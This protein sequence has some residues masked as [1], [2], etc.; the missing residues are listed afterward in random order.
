[1][2]ILKSLILL[3]V[4][5]S[6]IPQVWCAPYR[7]FLC[8]SRWETIMEFDLNTTTTL[9]VEIK[10]NTDTSPVRF[11]W[12]DGTYTELVGTTDQNHT[13]DY[14]APVNYTVKIKASA[15]NNLTKLQINAGTGTDVSFD[16]SDIPANVTFL[17]VPAAS[18]TISGDI[19]DAPAGITYFYLR[20]SNTISGDIADAPAGITYF[21]LQGSNTVSG[22]IA[23][24]PAGI[25]S[26]T[27]L[28]S[29]TV[30]GDIADA[31]AGI[32]SFTLLGS[33]TLSG[34]IADAPAGI[35][36]F[37]LRGSNTLSGDIADA[38]AGITSFI[39]LGS[40]TLS[41]DIA[42]VPASITS[43][44]LQGSNTLSGDI[45][46]VPASITS[47]NLQGSNTVSDYSGVFPFNSAFQSFK[48]I[49][50]SGGL[51][52]SEVDQLLI[53]FDS[54]ISSWSGDKSVVLTGT[55]AA[56]TSASD[57]AVASLQGKG[58]TVTT[59]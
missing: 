42:D 2:K 57:A 4:L 10:T 3:V 24:A 5:F 29:N 54:S 34:D 41:G 28:G 46:D 55:N 25:T 18:N 19:A 1:M 11:Y 50:V 15:E 36:S 43:F 45:A 16:L 27:L 37:Y 51:S 21:N 47:F 39:L 53:D 30:S 20:G 38:P 48:I 31:P 44:N 22:D 56:R 49:P 9:P 13:K 14:G 7:A 6:A 8:G 17:S 59:N 23:D 52:S 40:N 58:V 33:N 26:F 12:G 35:T 32:T